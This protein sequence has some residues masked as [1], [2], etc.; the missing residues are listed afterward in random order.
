MPEQILRSYADAPQGQVHYRAAGS[1]PAILLLHQNGMTSACFERLIPLL[2]DTHRVVAFDLP[3]LGASD[4][5]PH[6]YQIG[7]YAAHLVAAADALGLE[8]L[9]LFGHHTGASVGV[10]IAA[11]YPGRVDALTLDGVPIFDISFDEL[12]ERDPIL[13]GLM[14]FELDGS[15]ITRLWDRIVRLARHAFPRPFDDSALAIIQDEVL[16]R[17]TAGE[18]NRDVYRAVF[19][20]DPRARLPLVEAPTLLLAGEGDPLSRNNAPADALLRRSR[21]RELSGGSYYTT[22]VDAELLAE[23]ILAFIQDPG[24]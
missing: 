9:S 17:L 10:E 11:A 12:A 2:A 16:S 7:D 19:A 21:I 22:Y 3:G 6:P 8:S 4:P 23:E 18:T 5:P 15:H 24:V 1:G 20:Y 14:R 13:Y